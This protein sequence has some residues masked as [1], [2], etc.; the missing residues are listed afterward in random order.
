MTSVKMILG[1]IFLGILALAW[2]S[3]QILAI[4]ALA[5]MWAFYIDNPST[6]TIALVGLGTSTLL[7]F[8][9]GLIWYLNALIEYIKK[10]E[11]R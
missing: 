5:Y 8:I 11:Q 6:I 9:I 4:C 1:C 10:E 7:A 2:V 3:L